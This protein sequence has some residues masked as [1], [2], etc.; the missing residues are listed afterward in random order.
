MN[1]VL[2]HPVHRETPTYTNRLEDLYFHELVRIHLDATQ[3]EM[4]ELV[5][6]VLLREPEQRYR[7]VQHA[8]DAISVWNNDIMSRDEDVLI[9]TNRPP[10]Q[11]NITDERRA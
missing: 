1:T 7:S 6:V 3:E 10:V 9:Y 5:A 4:R 2:N 8:A 11:S